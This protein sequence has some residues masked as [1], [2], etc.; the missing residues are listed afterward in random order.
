MWQR[1]PGS[2]DEPDRVAEPVSFELVQLLFTERVKRLTAAR[3]ATP[4]H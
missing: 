3:T 1:E 2:D 4:A